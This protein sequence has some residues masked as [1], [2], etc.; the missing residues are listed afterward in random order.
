MRGCS[1]ARVQKFLSQVC[2]Q[3]LFCVCQRIVCM[4]VVVEGVIIYASA[5]YSRREVSTIFLYLLT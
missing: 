4:L 5:I 2:L 1:N 3:A